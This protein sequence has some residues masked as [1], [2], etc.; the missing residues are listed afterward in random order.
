VLLPGTF[1]FPDELLQAADLFIQPAACEAAPASLY[2]ALAAGLPVVAGDCLGIRE[3]VEPGKTAMVVP[4]GD[5]KQ[6][7]A[8]IEQLSDQPAKA[9]SLG[10][11]ARDWSRKQL[12]PAEQVDK[13]V[14]VVHGVLS[15]K[16]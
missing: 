4:P 8:A 3:V 10:S 15:T 2:E 14:A 11:A 7:A 6:L 16:Y 13:L 1:D 5:P 9:V 12:T